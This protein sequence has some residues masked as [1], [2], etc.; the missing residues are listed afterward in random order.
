MR[1][2]VL[3]RN[4]LTHKEGI[5]GSQYKLQLCTESLRIHFLYRSRKIPEG[6]GRERRLDQTIDGER[7][8][9]YQNSWGHE[10]GGLS[11]WWD[12]VW[13]RSVNSGVLLLLG[14]WNSGPLEIREGRKET[15][16]FFA[17]CPRVKK[18]E[19]KKRLQ[20]KIQGIR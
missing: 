9:S 12:K 4:R 3:I 11:Y 10:R 1:G 18:R 20:P 16:V 8:D 13:R 7:V 2:A 5:K 17:S 6:R 14:K 15:K 19:R